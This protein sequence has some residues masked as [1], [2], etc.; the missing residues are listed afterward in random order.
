MP[1]WRTSMNWSKWICAVAWLR[2]WIRQPCPIVSAIIS[3]TWI[4]MAARDRTL[5]TTVSSVGLPRSSLIRRRAICVSESV[6]LDSRPILCK[7]ICVLMWMSVE[8]SRTHQVWHNTMFYCSV[9][10]WNFII[11]LHAYMARFFNYQSY[12]GLIIKWKRHNGGL[13]LKNLKY[14]F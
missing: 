2:R 8:R 14:S 6:R 5:C 1:T 3:A 7:A 13:V 9:C 4:A 11:K 12:I 10:L